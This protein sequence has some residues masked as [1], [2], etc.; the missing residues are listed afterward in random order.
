MPW[1]ATLI[2]AIYV[3]VAIGSVR[4]NIKSLYPAWFTVGDVLADIVLL[5]LSL[6]FWFQPI[7]NSLQPLA[8]TLL[9]ACFA[10]LPFSIRQDLRE[11]HKDQSPEGRE[12]YAQGGIGIAIALTVAAPLYWWAFNYAV[13]RQYAGT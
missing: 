4:D 11:L 2:F 13:L 7:G 6:S 9:A 1:W 8:L 5:G 12:T 10:W 3:V